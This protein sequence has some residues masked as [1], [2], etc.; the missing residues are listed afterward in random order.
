ML[1]FAVVCHLV[2]G[3]DSLLDSD[4]M[5]CVYM[6]ADLVDYVCVWGGGVGWGGYMHTKNFASQSSKLSLRRFG[7]LIC[8]ISIS[9]NAC[10]PV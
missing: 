10:N 9:L 2:F 4:F 7:S 3:L 6:C 1:G 5:E 8:A